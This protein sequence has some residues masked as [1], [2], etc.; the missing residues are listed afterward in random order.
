MAK[1]SEI[2]VIIDSI[3]SEGITIT[4]APIKEL[5]RKLKSACSEFGI[6]DEKE[7]LNIVSKMRRRGKKV[8]YSAEERK[9]NST[10][11]KT[12]EQDVLRLIEVFEYL[13]HQKSELEREIQFYKQELDQQQDIFPENDCYEE[14]LT[15]DLLALFEQEF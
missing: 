1:Q 8:Q 15:P 12:V 3:R 5:K 10:F 11:M 9:R 14:Y 7:L 13:Q 4:D 2:Q 6:G